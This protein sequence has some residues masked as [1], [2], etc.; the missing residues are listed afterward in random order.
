LDGALKQKGIKPGLHVF[1][2]VVLLHIA[3]WILS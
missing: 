1:I 3:N 2:S